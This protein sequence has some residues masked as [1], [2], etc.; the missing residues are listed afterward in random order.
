M[1][2][3]TRRRRRCKNDKKKEDAKKTKKEK[4]DAKMTKQ[5]DAKKSKKDDGD[6]PRMK[7]K[8]VDI[9]DTT[10]YVEGEEAFAVEKTIHS[11]IRGGKKE[12][13]LEWEGYP[14][15][16]NTWEPSDI[17]CQEMMNAYEEKAKK[18]KMVVDKNDTTSDVED[19]D[20][21]FIVD[22][23]IHSQ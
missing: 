5:E 1:K 19:E 20:K 22:K 3:R 15:S 17:V 2:K 13:L 18:K 6:G 23:V 4:E 21:V 9:N 14:A 10:A 12:Y 11:K 8:V 7:I 16:G